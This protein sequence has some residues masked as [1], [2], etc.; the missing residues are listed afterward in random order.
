MQFVGTVM[1]KVQTEA[2]LRVDA[3][4]Q[5]V[6]QMLEKHL[7]QDA[8]RRSILQPLT[9]HEELKRGHQFAKDDSSYCEQH[10]NQAP[11]LSA[12]RH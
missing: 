4:L 8:I 3:M 7:R 5:T 11:L 6:V 10:S 1:E 2:T 9:H 12:P